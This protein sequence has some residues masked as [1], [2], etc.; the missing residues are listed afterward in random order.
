VALYVVLIAGALVMMLP[1]AYTVSTAL[2]PN[3]FVFEASFV[4]R[5]P[6]HGRQLRRRVERQQ[7]PALLPQQLQ[8]RCRDDVLTVAIATT[9]AYA[10]AR[11]RFPGKNVLFTSIC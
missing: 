5:Q 9:Q 4:P 11:L 10:F 1:F 8:G 7:F 2:K 6:G 3:A